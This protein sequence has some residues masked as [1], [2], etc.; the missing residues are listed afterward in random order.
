MSSCYSDLSAIIYCSYLLFLFLLVNILHFAF[1][2]LLSDTCDVCF[3]D[4]DEQFLYNS[5]VDTKENK[6]YIFICVFIIRRLRSRNVRLA[7]HVARVGKTRTASKILV[8]R[9]TRRT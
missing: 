2:P 9:V 8:G 7:G 3:V 4:E 6:S 5:L 1:L